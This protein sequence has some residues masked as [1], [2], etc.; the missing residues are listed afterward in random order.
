MSP[1]FSDHRLHSSSELRHVNTWHFLFVH[2]VI[3]QQITEYYNQS[4]VETE[5]E[6]KDFLLNK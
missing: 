3:K 5:P 1:S 4:D 6:S 2:D